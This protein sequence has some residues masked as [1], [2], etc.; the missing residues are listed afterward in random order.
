MLMLTRTTSTKPSREPLMLTPEE[1]SSIWRKLKPC[2]PRERPTSIL[3]MSSTAKPDMSSGKTSSTVRSSRWSEPSSVPRAHSSSSDGVF[4]SQRS[5]ESGVRMSFE[6][7]DASYMPSQSSSS[8]RSPATESSF[9]MRS[10][11]L[12]QRALIAIMS[13]VRLPVSP[14]FSFSRSG[15][16]YSAAEEPSRKDPNTR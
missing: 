15:G 12:E 2:I 16:T 3:S 13:S 6:S 9:A 4:F 5:S 14:V 10:E 11:E 1:G 7:S 8:S